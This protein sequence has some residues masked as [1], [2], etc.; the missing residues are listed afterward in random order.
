M[1]LNLFINLFYLLFEVSVYFIII[2]VQIVVNS[3]KTAAFET[4]WQFIQMIFILCSSAILLY[5]SW[6]CAFFLLCFY[7]IL[8][9][10]RYFY[11]FLITYIIGI[12][13]I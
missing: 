13:I 9:P 1:I 2:V 6:L 4:F 10:V 7:F 8:H 11:L 5:I 3:L 12:S